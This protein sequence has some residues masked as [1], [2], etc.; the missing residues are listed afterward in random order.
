M[1]TYKNNEFLGGD[2]MDIIVFDF[3]DNNDNFWDYALRENCFILHVPKDKSKIRLFHIQSIGIEFM[4]EKEETDDEF[5][6]L[7]WDSNLTVVFANKAQ[8]LIYMKN[9][10]GLW[11]KEIRSFEKQIMLLNDFDIESKQVHEIGEIEETGE[12]FPDEELLN[13]MDTLLGKFYAHPLFMTTL[14]QFTND[15][16][17]FLK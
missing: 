12:K 14:K 4:P 1:I 2:L 8:A 5:W 16:A 13:E 9:Y 11:V 6:E 10:V 15:L 7:F 3:D 17:A